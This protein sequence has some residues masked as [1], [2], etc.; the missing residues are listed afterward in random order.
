VLQAILENRLLLAAL[1]LLLL[2]MVPLI[3]TFGRKLRDSSR[4][5]RRKNS[6]AGVDR[7]A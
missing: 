4:P 6:R 1:I 7:R 3:I 5:D 2:L